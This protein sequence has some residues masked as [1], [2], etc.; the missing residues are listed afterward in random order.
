[1]RMLK[2]TLILSLLSMVAVQGANLPV[3]PSELAEARRWSAAKFEGVQVAVA[4]EPA[5]V[6]HAN[7]GVYLTKM[8]FAF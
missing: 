2:P 6:V 5:L 8:P 7:H 4:A 1:M 3:S